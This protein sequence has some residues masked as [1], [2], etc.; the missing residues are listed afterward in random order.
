[1]E[2]TLGGIVFSLREYDRE[3]ITDITNIKYSD[4][5]RY[6]LH[7]WK[8]ECNDS[9]GNGEIQDF[10]RSTKQPHQLE[11]QGYFFTTDWG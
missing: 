10:I 7:Q 2:G 1:M 8:I 11:N 3:Q 6:R 9:N 4:Q 5:G